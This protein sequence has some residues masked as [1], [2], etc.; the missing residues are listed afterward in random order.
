MDLNINKNIASINS[1]CPQASSHP[2]TELDQPS[3]KAFRSIN[4]EP[5]TPSQALTQFEDRLYRAITTPEAHHPALD[6]RVCSRAAD[7]LQALLAQ[8]GF[9]QSLG[10]IEGKGKRIFKA[11][12]TFKMAIEAEAKSGNDLAVR[13]KLIPDHH[14]IMTVKQP[15]GSDEDD[16]EPLTLTLYQ[17]QACR[18][19]LRERGPQ[20]MVMGGFNYNQFMNNL[21]ELFR[22]QSIASDSEQ[23]DL[24]RLNQLNTN[25]FGAPHAEIE[26]GDP[27]KYS[28]NA[29]LFIHVDNAFQRPANAVEP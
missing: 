15:T 27:Q 9:S 17:A 7:S 4:V 24:K 28:F 19:S 12:L 3:Q 23:L 21:G 8:H 16:V 1:A 13:L 2:G 5:L 18:F 26:L 6:T 25:C 14:L 22:L 29:E 10:T 20:E 11:F